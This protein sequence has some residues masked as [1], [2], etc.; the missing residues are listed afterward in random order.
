MFMTPALKKQI[1]RAY[2]SF[3]VCGA[4]NLLT[5]AG[6]ASDIVSFRWGSTTKDCIVWW[7]RWW[8][9]LTTAFT[10]A[11]I[12][13]HALYKAKAFS[14]SPSAGL[15]LVPA[16]GQN[17][18]KTSHAHSAL[19]AFQIS[20]TGALTAGTRTL[21]TLPMIQRGAWCPATPTLAQLG[22]KVDMPDPDPALL[23]L[24]T[25]EGFVIQNITAMGAAGVQKLMCEVAWSEIIPDAM[26]A[27]DDLS[28]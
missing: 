7:I 23:Y 15:S 25:N 28:V 2:G 9:Y 12:S 27:S 17:K 5:A 21:E 4:T 16:A 14:V 6:A 26:F 13:D 8:W 20:D 11:Q 10:N 22:E 18:R 3:R 24:A 19:T 1:V